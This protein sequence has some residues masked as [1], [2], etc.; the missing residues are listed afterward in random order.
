[1][2]SNNLEFGEFIDFSVKKRFGIITLNRVSRANALTT[3]MVKN[4]KKA[5]KYCQ[6]NEKIRG[7]IF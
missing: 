3:D 6:Y 5:V 7:I 2:T 4:L 1:M